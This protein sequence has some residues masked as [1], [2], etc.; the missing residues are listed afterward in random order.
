[1]ASG[2]LF[3]LTKER[4]EKGFVTIL[5]QYYPTM[6]LISAKKIIIITYG[7]FSLC[8]AV[9]LFLKPLSIKGMAWTITGLLSGTLLL[10]HFFAGFW[11]KWGI[12]TIK[13][14]NGQGHFSA[15]ISEIKRKLASPQILKVPRWYVIVQRTTDNPIKAAFGQFKR[16]HWIEVTLCHNGDSTL[17]NIFGDDFSMYRDLYTG[18]YPEIIS[19]PRPLVLYEKEHIVLSPEQKE[20]F[21]DLLHTCASLP[22]SQ[23]EKPSKNA[24]QVC[25]VNGHT[26]ELSIF[27]NVPYEH[28]L[29]QRQSPIQQF[30]FQVHNTLHQSKTLHQEKKAE[31][32]DLGQFA[33]PCCGF[34]TVQEQGRFDLCEVCFWEDDALQS[35]QPD[36]AD[37]ANVPCLLEAIENFWSYSACERES[38]S[39]VRLP[40]IEEFP[41]WPN[42]CH[43]VK[44]FSE[45]YIPR[46]HTFLQT[47]SEA[48]QNDFFLRYGKFFPDKQLA[49]AF[50]EFESDPQFGPQAKQAA[51]ELL[52]RNE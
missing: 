33:C 26:L 36:Y 30:L 23:T 8:I 45:G 31:R 5:S 37:G 34:I 13:Y 2:F 6:P 48:G 17:E 38:L 19:G 42:L 52:S 11:H 46:L 47:L 20:R 50:L 43:E 4:V 18:Q 7:M 41:H 9:L 10:T 51:Q 3:F 21:T 25:I 44:L 39:F 14:Q 29:Q 35:S 40:K 22:S 49:E 1:M 15:Y 16:Y 12:E 32:N 24:H 28:K 27:T